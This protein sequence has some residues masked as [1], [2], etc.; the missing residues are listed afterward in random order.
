M[1]E[2]LKERYDETWGARED[3]A[4]PDS[5]DGTDSMDDSCEKQ[6]V[7]AS[8]PEAERRMQAVLV[9]GEPYTERKSTFQVLSRPAGPAL[10]GSAARVCRD[11]PTAAMCY[12]LRLR[13]QCKHGWH[14]APCV[15]GVREHVGC[16]GAG[17]CDQHSAGAQ[18][19]AYMQS[20]GRV[21]R[22]EGTESFVKLSGPKGP[23]HSC[24]ECACLAQLAQNPRESGP[25]CVPAGT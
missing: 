24:V 4:G 6:A 23:T 8:V 14:S 5:S 18:L 17:G 19:H 3:A 7:P 12:R 20:P 9:T 13:Q 10:S 1:I 15:S 11:L 22:K 2:L 16:G 25:S 21:A